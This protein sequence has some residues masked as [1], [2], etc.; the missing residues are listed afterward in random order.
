M[1][2][3]KIFGCLSLFLLIQIFAS[4]SELDEE[5]M[6]ESEVSELEA[7]IQIDYE[8]VYFN[9][10][11]DYNCAP[12]PVE[13][14]NNDND[15]THDNNSKEEIPDDSDNDGYSRYGGYNEYSESDK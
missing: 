4:D 13:E 10:E 3:V 12:H 8:D 6:L 9:N 1:F 2:F 5:L 15:Y 11:L 14:M 7:K